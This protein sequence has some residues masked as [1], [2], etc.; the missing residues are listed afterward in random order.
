MN[1]KPNS[2]RTAVVIAAAVVLAASIAGFFAFGG[3]D[4]VSTASQNTGSELVTETTA[5]DA[6]S[7]ES[8]DEV[9]I[10]SNEPVVDQ[11]TDADGSTE[12]TQALANT[13]T[14]AA[15]GS[16][17][18]LADTAAE[19]TTTITFTSSP[20]VQEGEKRGCPE[21]L[22]LVGSNGTEPICQQP[23]A[24]CP[25]GYGVIGGVDGSLLCKG[26]AGDV[27]R[28]APDGTVTIDTSVPFDGPVCQITDSD[29]KVLELT[30]AQDEAECLARG[31]EYFPNGID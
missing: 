31:G 25:D 6:A 1:L 3:G 17:T 16:T 2:A 14:T 5:P 22:I 26:A 23:G 21:G 20:P 8:A 12:G 28:V 10:P 29:G 27:L 30:L 18:T 4:S 9:A 15:G 19:T 24:G 11:T 13:S 7:D